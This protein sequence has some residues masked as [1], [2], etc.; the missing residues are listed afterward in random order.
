MLNLTIIICLLISIPV[1]YLVMVKPLY[2]DA[3]EKY[4]FPHPENFEFDSSLSLL[5]AISELETDY[6]MGKLSVEDYESLS[7]EY[8][9]SY[10]EQQNK[11]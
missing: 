10:L 3:G 5:E 7:L 4:F 9:R 6:K 11:K 8:K 1:V 2:M